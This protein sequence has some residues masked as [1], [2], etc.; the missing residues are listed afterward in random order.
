MP[1]ERIVCDRCG[2]QFDCSPAI[3]SECWCV[4]EAFRLPMPLP[5]EVGNIRN[6]LCPSCLR[7]VAQ[8]LIAAGIGPR[9]N[10]S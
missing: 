5:P 4:G 10:S 6:C 7:L 1:P 9:A 8:A 2:S 3:D